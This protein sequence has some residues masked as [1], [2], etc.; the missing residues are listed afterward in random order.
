MI[1]DSATQSSSGK[2][3]AGDTFWFCGDEDRCGGEIGAG[4]EFAAGG[5]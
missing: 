2:D 5:R 3:V 1:E 4:C